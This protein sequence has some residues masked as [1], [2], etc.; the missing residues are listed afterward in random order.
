MLAVALT[1]VAE[2]KRLNKSLVINK[3]NKKEKVLGGY[4]WHLIKNNLLKT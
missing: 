3:L 1:N 2:Q 4:K